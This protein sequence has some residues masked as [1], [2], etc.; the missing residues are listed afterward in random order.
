MVTLDRTL[1]SLIYKG[2]LFL[3]IFRVAKCISLF[4]AANWKNKV[5]KSKVRRD[6]IT[7]MKFY[8]VVSLLVMKNL[9]V[10][11]VIK[12]ERVIMVPDLF[13]IIVMA[14]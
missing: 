12:E 4:I 8:K 1:D 6:E 11:L 5:G 10:S 7:Q 13:M 9:H 2:F 14:R 3:E